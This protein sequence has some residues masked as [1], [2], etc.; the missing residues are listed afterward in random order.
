MNMRVDRE[1]LRIFIMNLRIREVADEER[2]TD[3]DL[4][5]ELAKYFESTPTAIDL[6]Y[7][8]PKPF[9]EENDTDF[10]D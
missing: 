7:K 2:L 1:K 4:V 5:E 9:Y 6:E 8:K 10:Y 3:S